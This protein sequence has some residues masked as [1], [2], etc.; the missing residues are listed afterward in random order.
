MTIHTFTTQQEQVNSQTNLAAILDQLPVA[1]IL[2]EGEHAPLV[3]NSYVSELTGIA[4]DALPSTIETFFDAITFKPTDPPYLAK[5]RMLAMLGE[6]V[7]CQV[8]IRHSGGGTL[9]IEAIPTLLEETSSIG[10]EPA[11]D[12]TVVPT[13]ESTMNTVM[14]SASHTLEIPPEGK[15]DSQPPTPSLAW[16]MHDISNLIQS[17]EII[18]EQSDELYSLGYIIS[19]DLKAP[20]LSIKGLTNLLK[21]NPILTAEP[22]TYR[23][24]ETIEACAEQAQTLSSS[25]LSYYNLRKGTRVNFTRIETEKLIE[26][27]IAEQQLQITERRAS[28]TVIPPIPSLFGEAL[29]IYQVFS[30]LISNALKY[31]HPERQPQITI[32]ATNTDTH[33]MISVA[34]NGLGIPEDLADK[35]FIPFYRIKNAQHQTQQGHGIGLASVKKIMTLHRGKVELQSKTDIGSTFRLFFPMR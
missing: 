30:N 17:K 6:D 1:I 3:Y 29:R 24:L 12:S 16:V 19:H 23:T 13:R 26:K 32:S 33:T 27:V 15:P 7:R 34:D 22:S 18:K 8:E 10:D 11:D 25:I 4:P 28:I 14:R 5:C 20:I 9:W 21:A 35:V 2:E 31:S